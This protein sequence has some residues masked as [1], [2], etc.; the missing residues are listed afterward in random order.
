MVNNITTKGQSGFTLLE[1]IIYLALFSVLMSGALRTVQQLAISAD[2]AERRLEIEQT[3]AFVIKKLESIFRDVELL[4]V[5]SSSL[6]VVSSHAQLS[7]A[8]LYEDD[9]RIF[10]ERS[11]L[12]SVALTSARY[13]VHDIAVVRKELHPGSFHVE[14]RFWIDNQFFMFT[15][16]GYE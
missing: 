16:D 8:T 15:H 11:G 10:L 6:Q 13:Q 7:V 9:G 4:T 3:G 5:S 1:V 2:A 14:V 12:E